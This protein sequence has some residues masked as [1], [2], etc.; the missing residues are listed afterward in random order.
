[1]GADFFIFGLIRSLN[2]KFTS[3]PKNQ[4][5]VYHDVNGNVEEVVI[6]YSYKVKQGG[7]GL[8]SNNFGQNK[9]YVR[10]TI[11]ADEI[12]EIETDTE[13][14]FDLEPGAGIMPSVKKPNSLG[15]IPAV[16]VLNKP[17]ASGTE[18]E[19]EFDPFMEQIVLHNQLTK[20]IA[21]KY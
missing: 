11:T 5:R 10:L 2:I 13:L 19:G 18:G 4:Y 1:M 21:K 3:L 7:L 20:N 6:L 12:S 8:P 9:R 14:S 17:N 16:E 15:F